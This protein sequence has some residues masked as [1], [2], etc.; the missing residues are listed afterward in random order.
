MIVK[1]LIK[2]NACRMS[3]L[4]AF[5]IFIIGSLIIQKKDTL[6]TFD[7]PELKQ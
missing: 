4:Q 6:K 1:R 3:A 5:L 7:N 2:R